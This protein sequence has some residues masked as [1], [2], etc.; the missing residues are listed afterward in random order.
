LAGSVELVLDSGHERAQ[1]S[2]DR[3]S[4]GVHI[5]PMKWGI[6]Y[7]YSDNAVLVVFASHLYDAEDYIRDYG[8]FL[9][10]V[11]QASAA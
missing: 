4:L 9:H 6:Q 1:V 3:P 10:H 2:L 11:R 5:P 8:S 7:K